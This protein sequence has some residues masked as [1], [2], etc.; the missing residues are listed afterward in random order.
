MLKECLY[1]PLLLLFFFPAA[2]ENTSKG[3]LVKLVIE[4]GDVAMTEHRYDA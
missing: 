4:F 1:Y 3:S 2:R